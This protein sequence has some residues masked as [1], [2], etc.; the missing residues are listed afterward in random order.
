[1]FVSLRISAAACTNQHIIRCQCCRKLHRIIPA[2]TISLGQQYCP[3]K[4]GAGNRNKVILTTT[5][6]QKEI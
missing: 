6:L 2:K 1:M 4:D 3:V 5:V